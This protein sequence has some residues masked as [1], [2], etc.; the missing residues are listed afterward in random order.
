MEELFTTWKMGAM[1]LDIIV[2]FGLPIALVM[3]FR[4]KYDLRLSCGIVGVGTYVVVN[5]LLCGLFDLLIYY[6]T[7]SDYLAMSNSAA[8]IF[9]GLFHGLL[10]FGGYFLIMKFFLKGFDRKENA[11]MFGLGLSFIDSFYYNAIGAFSNFLTATEVDEWGLDAYYS[12]FEGDSLD[13]AKETVEALLDMTVADIIGSVI[14]MI[15][16]MGF[17]IAV[18][19]LLFQ[20][21]KRAGKNY[22]LPTIGAGIVVFNVIICYRSVDILSEVAYLIIIAVLTAAAGF[23]AYIY[24][25]AD[26]EEAR[27]K[28]DF[29]KKKN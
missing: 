13:V 7:I 19:V 1:L 26:K 15:L 16:E 23:G 24:Y 14:F 21:T 3:L 10:Q 11:L 17:F 22:L 20:A 28:A 6:T 25:G 18:S 29:V 5:S 9:Y 8:A 27:G 2:G 12:R 4:K